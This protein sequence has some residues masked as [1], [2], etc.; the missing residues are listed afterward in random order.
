[1]AAV[2]ANTYLPFDAG[3]GSAVAESGW[4]SMAQHWMAPG[5]L[6]S[7]AGV[8][9]ALKP[10]AGAGLQVLVALGEAWVKGHW[11]SWTGSS[12]LTVGANSSGST[13]VDAIVIRADFVNNRL[14][15]DL[16]AGTPGA[17]LPALTQSSSVWEILIGSST[18]VSGGSSVTVA[19]LRVMT[20]WYADGREPRFRL[21][22]G[23]PGQTG[24]ASGSNVVATWANGTEVIDTEGA[25]AVGTGVFTCP[26]A[27]SGRWKFEFCSNVAANNTGIRA[28]WL[29]HS[30]GPRRYAQSSQIN[31]G[32]AGSE[33][34]TGSA[35]IVLAAGETVNV[36]MFQTSGTT[37]DVNTNADSY[38][39]GRLIGFK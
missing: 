28:S 31:Q 18:L 33:I 36:V 11:A 14:E 35:E 32:G 8:R 12:A 38:F 29:S 34:F 24:I 16:V 23:S 37:L 22:G 10:T 2:V 25:I 9:D 20:G 15:L 1:M 39:Q 7:G 27:C 26:A 30:V 4:R 17:G 5:P 3:A 6:V 13:R 19:D 21:T